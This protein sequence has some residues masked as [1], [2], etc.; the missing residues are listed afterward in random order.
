MLTLYET[1]G[2]ENVLL[3]EFD[4]AGA[5]WVVVAYISGDENML[6]VVRSGKSP[7][8]V[9]G[10]LIS[11]ASEELV[12]AEH[13]LVGNH[14]DARKIEELRQP[15][16][17]PEGIF[18]PRSMSIRQAGKKS[19]H[20]LNYGMKYR[21]AALEWEIPENDAKPIVEAYSTVAYPGLE[22]GFWEPTRAQL[23][24]NRTLTNCFGRKVRLMGEWGN[25][26]F[27]QAYSFVPQSTVVDSCLQAL[28]Q[29]Y[30]DAAAYM[31]QMRMSAQTHD[32]LMAQ[33][34]IPHSQEGWE[35]LARMCNRIAEYM[36]PELE[37]GG[38]KFRL[39]VDMKVG[40]SWGTMLSVK[41]DPAIEILADSLQAALVELQEAVPERVGGEVSLEAE[42]EE[43]T[44]LDPAPEPSLVVQ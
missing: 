21:R 28:C 26:L 34:P 5:E 43:R 41:L 40:I 1:N 42:E 6:G 24:E 8:I 17:I 7:H 32:S 9:T 29:A 2:G 10:S 20:G 3:I 30:E 27:D 19:N 38:H 13:K 31:A 37:Y 11:G 18:L 36:S 39:G 12:L 23:R 33:H 15:L 44:Y 25:D 35:N 22:K 16:T 14:T 4:L